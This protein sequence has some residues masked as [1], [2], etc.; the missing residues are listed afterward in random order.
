MISYLRLFF[1][2]LIVGLFPIQFFAQQAH[3][4]ENHIIQ[5]DSSKAFLLQFIGDGYFPT[6]YFDFDLKYLIKF[7][8]YE[9]FRTGLGGVTNEQFSQ[10]FSFRGYGVYGFRDERFKYSLAGGLR[11]L[12]ERNT[13][14]FLTY[15]DDLEETGSTSFLTDKRLFKLFEPRLFNIDLFHRH[16]TRAINVEHQ[17]VRKLVFETELAL[18][19]IRPTYA[20]AFQLPSGAVLTEYDVSSI[21]LGVQWSPF[22]EF[23]Y[24][25]NTIKEAYSGY[26]KINLQY[27]KSIDNLFGSDL[28][29][30]KLDF[31]LIHQIKHRNQS[32]SEIVLSGG[33]ASGEV[34]LQYLYHAFPNNN[35]QDAI[36]KRFSISGNNSFETM[37]FNE[38]FSDQLATLILRHE[39]PRFKISP[40]FRPQ[41]ALLSKFAIGDIRNIDRHQ[42]VSFKSLEQGFLESGIEINRLI[43]GFGLGFAYR[44][45]AN[46]LPNFE[47]NIAFKFTFN[48]EFE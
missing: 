37:Y 47:D 46:H 44:Y 36:M 15:T 18:R 11:I 25:N 21:K 29:F 19:Y 16:I 20:Y 2:V 7:N 34:P 4:K 23:I 27:T 42:N 32:Q 17:L 35:N 24:I 40:K 3:L 8:Q 31:R 48:L 39:F 1:I 22:S 12:P 33:L 38:F 28:D 6:K 13:W 5:E 43:F 14:V 10:N 30:S 41:L 26:P 45:G 9:G